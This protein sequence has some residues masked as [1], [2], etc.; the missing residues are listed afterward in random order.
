MAAAAEVVMAFNIPPQTIPGQLNQCPYAGPLGVS[1]MHGDVGEWHT[2][3][4]T[5]N[6]WDILIK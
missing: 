6:G 2:A 4:K 3:N 5:Q 1:T